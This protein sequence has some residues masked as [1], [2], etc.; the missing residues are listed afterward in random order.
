MH[1]HRRR[2]VAD[3]DARQPARRQCT[4]DRGSTDL[5]EHDCTGVGIAQAII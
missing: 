1:G 5:V 2:D 3:R 4:T